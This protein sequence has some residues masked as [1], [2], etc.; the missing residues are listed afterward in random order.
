MYMYLDVMK[1]RKLTNFD[2][3]IEIS[4]SICIP[5]WKVV[6]VTEQETETEVVIGGGGQDQD[7]G[8]L[9]KI[10]E[11]LVVGERDTEEEG[12]VLA[13]KKVEFGIHKSSNSLKGAT[14]WGFGRFFV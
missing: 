9:T 2:L 4:H 6:E 13:Q 7:P 10:A 11:T 3:N 1:K 8:A 14:S 12:E 5:C